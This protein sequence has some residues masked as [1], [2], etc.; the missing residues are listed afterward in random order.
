MQAPDPTPVLDLIEAFRRS[1]TMFT[2]LRLGVFDLLEEAPAAAEQLAR[3][4]G[5]HPAALERLLEGC[6][7]LGLLARGEGVFSNTQTARHYLTSS[8]PHSL[9]GYIRYSDEALYRL[10]GELESAVREGSPRWQQVFGARG[11]LFD[12]FYRTEEARAD[13]LGGMHGLGLL[14]SPAVV[15]VFNL[16]AYETL[17]DLGGGTGHLAIAACERY[18]RMRATVFDRP[19]VIGYARRQISVSPARERIACMAGDFFQDPLPRASLYALARIL[20]DWSDGRCVEL[21][22]RV[23]AA[24]EPGGA[25][26]VAEMLLDEDRCGPPGASM[27]SLNML[28]CTEGRERTESEYRTLL[29]AAGFAEVEA[30]RTAT[31]LDALLARKKE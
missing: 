13:F 10:W 14:S 17:V 25:V 8:S 18:G 5:T 29:E 2:A 21:L 23:H 19:D 30:R 9:A 31:L 26:L 28:V 1:K 7:A 6:A 27:Q 12:H 11:P 15:R 3:R 24:L 20:H 16:N 4:T 22:R